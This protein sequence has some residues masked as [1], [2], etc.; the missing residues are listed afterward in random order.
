MKLFNLLIKII[1][2]KFFDLVEVE[3]FLNETEKN[4]YKLKKILF[5][6]VAVFKK[7]EQPEGKLFVLPLTSHPANSSLKRTQLKE[8]GFIYQTKYCFFAKV[9]RNKTHDR[10]FYSGYKEDF[11][12][13]LKKIGVFFLLQI[14]IFVFIFIFVCFMLFD[15]LMEYGFYIIQYKN[16]ASLVFS[17]MAL[18]FWG[19][20]LLVYYSYMCSCV[21]SEIK[22]RGENKSKYMSI[23]LIALN[24]LC[25]ILVF[26]SLPAIVVPIIGF[27]L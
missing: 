26:L 2:T 20:I 27:Y 14:A 5:D 4:G 17:Q 9:F 6:C 16:L 11:E 7:S 3:R 1:P 10:D 25:M 23:V 12:R 22:S 21:F 15:S 13:E 8:N 18:Y 19:F 24:F